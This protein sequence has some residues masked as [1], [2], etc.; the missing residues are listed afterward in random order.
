L[1]KHYENSNEVE[2][3]SDIKY[4]LLSVEL[5]RIG[6][7]GIELLGVELSREEGNFRVTPVLRVISTLGVDSELGSNLDRDLDIDLGIDFEI[8]LEEQHI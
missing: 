5:L 4:E 8:L 3:N 7:C 6:L 2:I 1:H